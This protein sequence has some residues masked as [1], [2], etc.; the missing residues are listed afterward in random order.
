MVIK[1]TKKEKPRTLIQGQYQ[2]RMANIGQQLSN[3]SGLNLVF[4]FSSPK[5]YI[6]G[7]WQLVSF[8][9][10]MITPANME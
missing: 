7:S 2:P 6:S 3:F 9:C 10:L 1:G 5:I 8:Y 4:D